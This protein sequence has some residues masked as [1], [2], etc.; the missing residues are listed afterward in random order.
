MLEFFRVES[1]KVILVSET[2]IYLQKKDKMIMKF[3]VVN[4]LDK[5]L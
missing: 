3:V 4:I 5:G 1:I 2:I